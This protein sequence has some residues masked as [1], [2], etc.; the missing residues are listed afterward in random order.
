MAALLA[1]L[2]ASRGLHTTDHTSGRRAA[3][4]AAAGV[5]RST[6]LLAG[7]RLP[8]RLSPQ[9][10]WR[11]CRAL[12]RRR[13]AAAA[14]GGDSGGSGGSPSEEQQKQQLLQVQFQLL[15]QLIVR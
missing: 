13:V 12:Q 14:G 8:A 2:A 5:S 4:T 11:Q 1:P 3:A 10:H 15:G 6:L 9:R 7:P